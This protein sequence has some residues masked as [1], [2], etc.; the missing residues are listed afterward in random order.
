MY[1]VHFELCASKIYSNF[2]AYF[3]KLLEN[4]IKTGEFYVTDDIKNWLSF[5]FQVYLH[6]SHAIFYSKYIL[7]K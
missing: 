1:N 6:H 5:L 3:L 7:I 4:H 2:N